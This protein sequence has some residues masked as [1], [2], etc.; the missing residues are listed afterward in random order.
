MNST[1]IPRCYSMQTNDGFQYFSDLTKLYELNL[2]IIII[3]K[4]K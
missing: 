3:T 1:I 2:Q 4:Y